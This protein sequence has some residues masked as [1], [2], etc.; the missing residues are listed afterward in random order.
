MHLK[1]ARIHV[2]L[3]S[4]AHLSR[5]YPQARG[6][7]HQGGHGGP[8]GGREQVPQQAEHQGEYA[9]DGNARQHPQHEKLPEVGYLGRG[10]T[11][12]AGRE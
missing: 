10:K 4:R 11:G 2:Q 8:L 7:L 1:Y 12:A 5:P 6:Y 9:A 3:Y